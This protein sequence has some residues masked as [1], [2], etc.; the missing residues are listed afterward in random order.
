MN[1]SNYLQSPYTKYQNFIE[2]AISS[3]ELPSNFYKKEQIGTS[4]YNNPIFSYELGSGDFC[5]LMTAGVHGREAINSFALLAMLNY[6]CAISPAMP[7]GF[8]PI[9]FSL[10]LW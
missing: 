8:P 1:F 7:I 3:Y 4:Y 10:F 2:E 6:Y 9:G 5:I